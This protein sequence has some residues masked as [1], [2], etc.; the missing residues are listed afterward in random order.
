[1]PTTSELTQSQGRSWLTGGLIGWAG[2]MATGGAW[3]RWM[4]PAIN[5]QSGT[6]ASEGGNEYAFAFPGSFFDPYDGAC[7]YQ[8]Y[9]LIAAHPTAVLCHAMI[10][11][12]I[13]SAGWGLDAD[14]LAAPS[15]ALD[16]LNRNFMPFRLKIQ[17]ECL[18][19][20]K[21]GWQSFELVYRASADGFVELA[22]PKPLL[23]ELTTILADPNGNVIGLRNGV[24]IPVDQ[25]MLF[26]YDGEGDNPHGRAR[27]EN[28][29]RAWANWMCNDDNMNR[30]SRKAAS[31]I[32]YI[33]YPAGKSRRPTKG[34][35][36]S[37]DTTAEGE[38]TGN[39]KIASQIAGS[40]AKGR[41]VVFPN[42]AGLEI[43]D[44]RNL[45]ELAKASMWSIQTIEMGNPGPMAQAVIESL[46]YLDA[47]I[48]RGYHRPERTVIEATTAGSRADSES[49]GDV[50]ISDSE[51]LHQLVTQAVQ[52]QIVDRLMEKNYGPKA[53]GSIKLVAKPIDEKQ[54]IIDN[55]LLDA[56]LKGQKSFGEI[57]RH[58]DMDA[59]FPRTGLP[60]NETAGAWDDMTPESTK[61]PGSTDAP[62]EIEKEDEA[63]RELSA[64]LELSGSWDPS[65][66]PRGND[67][68]FVKVT[69]KELT[70]SDDKKTI[71]DA[72]RDFAKRELIG[73]KFLNEETGH[74]IGFS[75]N[76][77]DKIVNNS[78]D[79]RRAKL[80]AVV[81][82]LIRTGT[83]V[84]TEE[85]RDK[86]P[87]VVAYHRFSAD[88]EYE[89]KKESVNFVVREQKDG[90][91]YYNHG[92]GEVR[93]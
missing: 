76:S 5:A 81:P 69:G 34:Q 68:R 77:I 52:T 42:H 78:A 72:A 85:A 18:R 28:I 49:H 80:V 39:A 41:G 16:F 50:A 10:V 71:R 24:N 23:P 66:H 93:K 64:I 26:T 32:P 20:L 33:G 92:F 13:L 8:S 60:V 6:D 37:G 57:A 87:N 67:G 14:K 75:R 25:M 44:I 9:R 38:L 40:M 74:E 31:T 15:D 46:R 35:S 59:W 2:N 22:K 43:D 55:K 83:R 47:M 48:C 61:V 1:M 27:L 19:A 30:L 70:N 63:A 54:K 86:E 3:S 21:Y 89:G 56:M 36:E 17:Y 51:Y 82:E 4:A 91:W 29:R 88:V 90:K 73:H 84:S 62:Q 58:I 79:I 11:M 65:Q 53:V 12:P 45:P 7:G